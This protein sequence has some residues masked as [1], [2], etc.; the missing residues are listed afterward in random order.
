MATSA[1]K[2]EG[3]KLRLTVFLVKD[4]YK[5]IEDFVDTNQLRRVQVGTPPSGGTLFFKAGFATTAPWAHVFAD[6]PGF[7]PASIVN[8][9]SRGIYVLKESGRWFCFTFGYTRHLL[10][11]AAVERNF[12]LIVSLNLGDPDS[13][14]AIDKT[15]ISHVGLQSREQ[16]G[17]DVGFDA[18]EFDTDIDILKSITAKGPRS[19]D[20]DQETYSGRDSFSLYTRVSLEDFSDIARRLYK[21]SQSTAYKKQYPW[22]DKIAEERDPTVIEKLETSLV[23]AINSENLEKIWMA[24]P[25]IVLWEELENFA[26]KPPSA[27]PTRAGPTLYPDLDLESWIRDARLPGKVKIQHL[28][29]R[30]VFQCF[31]DGREP[32]HWSVYRCLNAEIDLGELKYILNDG[33]WYNVEGSYVREID[34][35]YRSITNSTLALPKYGTL[36][37]PKYLEAVTRAHTQ[38]ALM[39]QKTVMTGGGRSRV[40]FCDLY[41]KAKDIVHVKQYGGSSLLSHLFSQALVSAGCFLHEAPFRSEVNRILPMSFRWADPN[42]APRP[43]DYTVCVAIMSRVRGQLELPFFSKVTL[44]HTLRGIQRMN[45]NVTKL[46]IER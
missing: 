16:A 13:I 46:K 44:N 36:T 32:A 12:G 27:N 4:G 1:K 38:Y 14:K 43:Q 19:G 6:A 37:E 10:T 25:E 39:D 31:K 8:T 17:R 40:E 5:N 11:E 20:D 7:N 45:F 9:H 23:A 30:K 26:Y 34:R 15:N 29:S 41:S 24:V 2:G 3:R 42:A 33:D 35:F 18:F 21:A 22:V 28:K